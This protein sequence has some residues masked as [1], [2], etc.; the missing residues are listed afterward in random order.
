MANT[1]SAK[2]KAI[3]KAHEHSYEPRFGCKEMFESREEEVLISG[4]AG[5]GKSRACLEKIF[6]ICLANPGTKAL[7]L[8][9]T[10]ASLGSSALST[11]RK[12]VIKEA[13]EVGVV[14]YYGGSS[15]EPPQYRFRNG[16]KVV[17]GGLDKPVRVMSTEYD[18]IYIQEATEC[19]IE[20][21]ESCKTRLRNWNISFQQ[22][23]MDCN[24][25]SAQHP[26]L[27]RTKDGLC[28]LIESRHEDN[29]VLFV[30]CPADDPEATEYR[31]EHLKLTERGRKY[32]AILDALTGV[33]YKRLRLGL[34]VSA[35]GIIYDEFDPARHVLPWLEDAEGNRLIRPGWEDWDRY[36]VIDFGLAHPF[37]LQ[38]WAI[39][40][41]GV[42]YMYREI[43]MTDRTVDVHAQTIMDI[44]CPE[45]V[46][47]K[48]Q[49]D[50]AARTIRMVPTLERQW[51]EPKP[52]T[53][54]CDHDAEGRRTF[55]KVTGLG[56]QPA[57]KFVS[58]G[59]DLHKVRLKANRVFLMADAVV[60]RDQVLIDELRP[61]CTADEYTG[62]A[63]KT[64]SEGRKMDEP[65]KKDDDGM[66]CCRYITM[67]F[68][69]RGKARFTSMDY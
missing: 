62:Y 26:L 11:W 69:Y 48:P 66:D 52:V 65:V 6:A 55:E 17:I 49:D 5:T 60:E 63:W 10:L 50:F 31:G 53:V 56:T 44:V 25:G 15:E 38:C 19:T 39:D 27:L 67:H 33:R 42:M 30:L 13:L 59:I 58:D 41:D 57:I 22:L 34:W 9:K 2:R 46:V 4:P 61:T 29:P 43:Y 1:L 47:M 21:I 28:K 23:L 51:I 68:D 8:R 16:S 36:W 14:V 54:I 32:I 12:F 24:P 20:D 37:V 3:G 18:I 45:V 7:I 64:N 35:E 40:P